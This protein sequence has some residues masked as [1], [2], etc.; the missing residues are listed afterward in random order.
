LTV[1]GPA[2]NPEHLLSTPFLDPKDSLAVE[3]LVV[4]AK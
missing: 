4:E 3:E 1:V 2:L